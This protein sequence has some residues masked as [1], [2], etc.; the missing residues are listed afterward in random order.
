MPV[1]NS[2][3]EAFVSRM[4]ATAGVTALI[5]T[6]LYPD[7]PTQDPTWPYATASVTYGGGD[8]RLSGRNTLQEYGLLVGVF[9]ATK[10][11]ADAIL[12]AMIAACDGWVD[13]PN[14]VK[15]CFPAGDRGEETLDDG[16]RVMRQTFRLFYLG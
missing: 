6:R 8:L 12:D 4:A 10:A 1:P 3:T 9:A 7:V 11:A 15:G 13:V 16:S 14:K 5:A 2:P